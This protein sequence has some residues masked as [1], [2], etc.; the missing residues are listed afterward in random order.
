MKTIN[1]IIFLSFHFINTFSQDTTFIYFKEDWKETTKDSAF[2][3]RMAYSIV[4]NKWILKENF[5]SGKL[6]YLAEYGDKKLTIKSGKFI[7]YYPWGKI[8]YVGEYI[9]NKKNGNWISYF[10]NEKIKSKEEYLNGN[11]NGQWIFNNEN[12]KIDSITNFNNDLPTSNILYF[13][14]GE[15]CYE[16]KYLDNKKH[17]YIYWDKKGNVTTETE[18]CIMPEFPGGIDALM[19]Y[20]KFK[21]RYP[22]Q[23][24]KKH[25]EGIIQVKFIID[26]DGNVDSPK[27][28]NNIGGGCDEEALRTVRAMPKWIPATK[29]GRKVPVIFILPISFRFG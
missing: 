12:G 20:L 15:K 17:E 22:E 29:C 25:V 2:N 4:K 1:F 26:K 8:K 23:A 13:E 14:S 16:E 24:L 11:K 18:N 21:I 28:L 27:L 10:E 5:Y 9:D 3:L 7:D 19:S 6:K